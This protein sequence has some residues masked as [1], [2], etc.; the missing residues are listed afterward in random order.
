MQYGRREFLGLSAAVCLPAI[1]PGCSTR[2]SLPKDLLVWG[3]EGLRD[4]SFIKPRAIAAFGK[5]VYAI[6]TTGRI[7]LFTENGDFLDLWRTPESDNGTPTAIAFGLDDRILVPDTHYSQILEYA[8]S[9]EVLETWGTYGTGPGEF[10]YPTGIVQ[11]PGGTYFISEYGVGAERVHVFARDRSFLREWGRQGDGPGE[12]SRAMAIE[13]SAD[14]TLFVADTANHRVQ[15]FD[16]SGMLLNIIGGMGKTE[17]ELTYPYDI[18]LAPDG[19]LFVAEYGTH[20]ISRFTSGGEFVESFG[21]PGR[22]DGEF[23]GPRGVAV[24]DSGYVFVADTDNH[25]IQRFAW[26]AIG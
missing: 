26:E 16:E 22:G 7:Q 1:L 17:G 21:R 5:I 20:R 23:N 4:G 13:R 10:I 2:R 6:D 18:A 15:C 3:G 11:A 24:S 8:P 25:R 14:G 9:G 12:F 19:S